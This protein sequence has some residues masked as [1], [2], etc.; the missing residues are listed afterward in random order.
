[1]NKKSKPTI[2]PAADEVLVSDAKNGNQQAF[3]ILVKRYQRRILLL[4]LRYTRV[5]ED[6]EDIV[7]ETFLKAFVHLHKFEGKSSFSTWATRIA[8]NQA[9]MSLRRRRAVHEVPIDDLSS[10]EGRTPV[11]EPAGA[12]PDPEASCS[13]KEGARILSAAMRQLRPEMR[14]AIQLKELGELSARETAVHMG[15]SV[16]TV[17]ARVFRARKELGKALS[18]YMGSRLMCGSGLPVVAEDAGGVSQIA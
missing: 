8:I 5:W 13:Q 17:K 18:R 12:S 1:M 4:A 6:A 2:P 16:G 14:R 9:L 7:Q 15:V 10:D 11:S 3:E